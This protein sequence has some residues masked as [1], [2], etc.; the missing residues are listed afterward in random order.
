M[1]YDDPDAIAVFEFCGSLGLPVFVIN[2]AAARK[3]WPGQEAL[4]QRATM[5]SKEWVVVGVVG[6]IRQMGP[7]Q[8]ARHEAYLP[9]AQNPQLFLT[10]VMRTRGDPL[11]ALPAVKTAIWSVYPNQ[12]FSGDTY[13]LD[14][15]M[16][17]LLAARRFNMA[18]LSLFGF[19][20]LVI[21]A[22]GIY[23][24]MA[25]VVAQRTGEIGVRMA[26]GA[27]RTSIAQLVVGDGI[28]LASIG[29]MVGLGAALLA[30]R[31]V[32]SVLYGVSR[33]DPVAFAGGA[34]LLLVV[35]AV[36]CVAPMLRATMIDPALAVR[37][38]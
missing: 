36:A 5:N 19:L 17:K 9:M 12:R 30:T 21:A 3:Y 22:V 8:P 25:Y 38:E 29:I 37:A 33:F 7:G 20:G 11:A 28:R 10:L 18:L 23:G 16:D 2:E 34:A 4:G 27:T 32:Q 15:Y 6:D 26:L 24:V 14:S 35:A 31:L 1:R 13:T